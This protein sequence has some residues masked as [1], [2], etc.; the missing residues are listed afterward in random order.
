MKS[1]RKYF[2][3]VEIRV[4]ALD[5]IPKAHENLLKERMEHRNNEDRLAVTLLFLSE[6][7]DG[8]SHDA[9]GPDFEKIWTPA[10]HNKALDSEGAVRN[11]TSAETRATKEGTRDSDERLFTSPEWDR[12]KNTPWGNR[13]ALLVLSRLFVRVVVAGRQLTAADFPDQPPESAPA[14]TRESCHEMDDDEAVA[15]FT[16]SSPPQ[17]VLDLF[18]RILDSLPDDSQ[19]EPPASSSPGFSFSGS[20]EEVISL[21]ES[22]SEQVEPAD[23]VLTIQITHQG[24]RV[25]VS[26]PASCGAHED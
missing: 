9:I 19:V 24:Y 6:H 13:H 11:I 17:N 4:D 18:L 2:S 3:W 20:P 15:A 16:A 10:K 7:Q 8:L 23:A 25:T 1:R 12:W 14:E 22:V 5:E 26:A 21:L